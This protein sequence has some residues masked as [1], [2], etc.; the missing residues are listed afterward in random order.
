MDILGPNG[1]RRDV[2]RSGGMKSGFAVS[3]DGQSRE[4][5]VV[6]NL[7][8]GGALLLVEN[9]RLIDRELILKIDGEQVRRPARVVWRTDAAVAIS[10]LT[11]AADASVSDGWVFAPNQSTPA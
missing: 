5:C 7:S 8:A 3:H 1:E 11:G 2:A 9:P 4:A 10:F 6:S